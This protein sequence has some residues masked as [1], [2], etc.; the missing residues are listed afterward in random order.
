MPRQMG[1]RRTKASSCRAALVVMLE[2]LVDMWWFSERERERDG[3]H[4][5]SGG[6]EVEGCTLGHSSAQK[7]WK[8]LGR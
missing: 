4:G 1:T 6:F 3:V 2:A 5:T 8:H 7:S